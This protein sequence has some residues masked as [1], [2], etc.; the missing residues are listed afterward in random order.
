MSYFTTKVFN[1]AKFVLAKIHNV[2][3]SACEEGQKRRLAQIVYY[4]TTS[5]YLQHY[6]DYFNGCIPYIN[7]YQRKDI[8]LDDPEA[9]CFA[10]ECGNVLS[11][12][13]HVTRRAIGNGGKI[14]KLTELASANLTSPS[15]KALIDV[16]EI[17][18][19]FQKN[20]NDSARRLTLSDLMPYLNFIM[21]ETLH[22][23]L[24]TFTL[25]VEYFDEEDETQYVTFQQ[26]DRIFR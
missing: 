5:P 2:Y 18:Q 6:V 15:S 22:I 20:I 24:H 7:V 19:Y 1:P 16:M 13:Y 17:M 25:A 26:N 9:D 14:D 21:E 12:P 8:I 3:Q 4:N 11:V 10:I 23:P